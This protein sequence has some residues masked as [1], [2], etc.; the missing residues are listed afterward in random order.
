MRLNNSRGS[1][2]VVADSKSGLAWQDNYA[3]NGGEIKKATWQDALV[4]CHELTS[5]VPKLQLWDAY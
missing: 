5:L 1:S 3:D 4:Y 2:G